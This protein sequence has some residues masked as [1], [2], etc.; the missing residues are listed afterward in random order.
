MVF[1]RVGNNRS[2]DVVLGVLADGSA[3]SCREISRFLEFG[4][5]CVEN[6]MRASIVSR[7]IRKAIKVQ[8]LVCLQVGR[9][10][11]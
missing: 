6:S 1:G 3:R 9:F 10:L 4:Q 5:K 2:K 11:L 8:I 7:L